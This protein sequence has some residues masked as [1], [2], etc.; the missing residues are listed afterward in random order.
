[1]ILS[2]LPLLRQRRHGRRV[3]LRRASFAGVAISLAA[4]GALVAGK[5]IGILKR[6]T[7]DDDY[8]ALDSAAYDPVARL[9]AAGW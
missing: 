4:T 2:R 9:R 8:L 6:A 3:V 5:R 7:V 1:M